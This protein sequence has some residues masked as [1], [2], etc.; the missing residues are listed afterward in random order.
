MEE[1][2][3]KI[4]IEN[5]VSQLKREYKN[6]STTVSTLKSEH[7]SLVSIIEKK[8]SQKDELDVDLNETLNTI[9]NAKVSWSQEKEKEEV[10]ISEKKREVEEILARKA[11][12]DTQE[13]KNLQI[14]EDDKKI[15]NDN[16]VLM[17]E[18]KDK[19]TDIESK[20][21]ILE[22]TKLE[23]QSERKL[24]EDEV[25]DFKNK[26]NRVVKEINK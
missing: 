11:E 4:K 21:T 13:Q 16:R 10:E 3:T 6:L 12:L 24:L 1:I 26:I 7:D 9:A 22:T 5:D 8:K 14:L 15:L 23:I 25:T 17:L 19:E 18:L 20:I 2:E